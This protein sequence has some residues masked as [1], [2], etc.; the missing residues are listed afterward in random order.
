[1]Y[2]YVILSH[3]L[4][5]HVTHGLEMGRTDSVVVGQEASL[6]CKGSQDISEGTCL[7]NHAT[8]KLL[9]HLSDGTVV[10]QETQD[11]MDNYQ[12]FQNED[13]H[14][15]GLKILNMTLQ[16]FGQWECKIDLRSGQFQLGLVNLL[17]VEDG[18]VK[19][20]RLPDTVLPEEYDIKLTPHIVEDN[21]T[22]D[23]EIIIKAV[24][25]NYSNSIF[26][27]YK[28]IHIDEGSVNVD[29]DE[30][31]LNIAGFGYDLDRDFFIIYLQEMLQESLIVNVKLRFQSFLNEDMKGFYRSSYF[32]SLSNTTKTLAVTKFEPISAR[33]AFPCFDEPAMK[34]KF[35]ITLV[36][37]KEMISLSNMQQIES[38]VQKAGNDDYVIDVYQQS[39]K[40]STY[41]VA[42]IVCEF[43]N[44]YYQNFTNVRVWAKPDSMDQVQYAA[45]IAPKLISYYEELFS[46]KY[47]LPKMDMVAVPDFQSGA[48]ENWGL[49]TYRDSRILYNQELF[50]LSSK[51]STLRTIA[52]E[53]AHQWF[54]NL[55]T[56]K[57]WND[58]WLNEGFATFINFI[59]G[60]YIEPQMGMKDN[61]IN[62][63]FFG[64]HDVFALDALKS[65]SAISGP[66]QNP[67]FQNNFTPISY[68][69]GCALLRMIEYFLTPET[70]YAGIKSYFD[71][72]SYNNAEMADL[73]R[74][75]ET[76]GH[77]DGTLHQDLSMNEIMDTWT[78]H[79]G[80][81][82]L[83]VEK[84]DLPRGHVFQLRQ[85]KFDL[86]IDDNSTMDD[87]LWFIPVSFILLDDISLDSAE[88]F[89]MNHKFASVPF[90]GSL[91]STYLFNLEEMGY[92]RVNYDTTNWQSLSATLDKNPQAISRLSRA[93]LLD[94]SLNL[95]RANLL[96]Y[97]LALSL[98]KYLR[99][100]TEYIPWFSGV[101][102]LSFLDR[103]FRHGEDYHLF[104]EFPKALI[105]DIL[106]KLV[107]NED[108]DYMTVHTRSLIMKWSCYFE[109]D[110]CI[111]NARALYNGWSTSSNSEY[112]L[113]PDD[114]E[115]VYCNGIRYGNDEDWDLAWERLQLTEMISERDSLLK[116]LA[117]ASSRSLIYLY[118]DLSIS[119]NSTIRNQ[120]K[121]YVYRAIGENIH[122]GRAMV[123]W[124]NEKWD[125]IKKFYGGAFAS[126]VVNMISSFP[127]EASTIE[128][129]ELYENLYMEHRADLGSAEKTFTEG[130]DKIRSNIKWKEHLYN[131]VLEWLDDNFVVP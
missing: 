72:H 114:K 13:V 128:D 7:M 78:L 91:N 88:V 22:V 15:C 31:E 131:S 34:A 116:G 53:L 129:F 4:L 55:V 6:W 29:M 92:Y 18:F 97:N 62:M 11:V 126:N 125:E 96:D 60:D 120:D 2:F 37:R 77:K 70:F 35:K 84:Y 5:H 109:M 95:A 43:N 57:W 28:F 83:H 127:E 63:N 80:F 101:K 69:K 75:L 76:Q 115:Y 10:D 79:K 50:P 73:W 32:D 98:T 52:H 71:N 106:S 56:M 61:M 47:P 105:S 100:E 58:L 102:A 24:V 121:V 17:S 3:L 1:M 117:C 54:G 33:R 93:Q 65:S 41:L 8:Q 107:E 94:D 20:V 38:G 82:V 14:V 51:E 130:M 27:H 67:E 12:A 86:E 25:N 103:M 104:R 118:L 48:M 112:F 49:I 64:I 111:E 16:D 99:K 21:Y 45:E 19:D 74:A 66:I 113:N 124:L 68:G 9:L 90:Q 89:W 23:G 108:D 46:T 39:V 30:F 122:G 26:L 87:T 36:R 85:E 81:P 119:H 59:G 40:M 110:L 123:E 42:F 44:T